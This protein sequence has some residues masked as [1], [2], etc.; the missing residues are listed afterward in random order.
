MLKRM[1]RLCGG[2]LVF[3]LVL[4]FVP[5]LAPTT[6]QPTG[7]FAD[8]G[9]TALA[10]TAATISS[11]ANNS[12]LASSSQVFTWNNAGANVYQLWVGSTPDATDLGVYYPGTGTTATATGLPVNGS[13]IYVTLYS[14]FGA[15]WLSNSYTYSASGAPPAAAINTPTNGTTLTGSSQTFTWNNAGANEYQLWL[16]STPGATDLGVYYPGTGTITNAT[17]LPVNG[18]TIYVTLF[19]MFGVTWYSNSYTYIA[20]NS[21]KV[22]PVPVMNGWWLLPGMLAAIGIFALRRKA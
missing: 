21:A 17:G 3:S 19:S 5:V 10:S 8:L 15:T 13:T 7:I 16:G 4:M 12:T 22:T 1:K 6:W 18:S 9:V 14:L 11:P 2:V 20:S